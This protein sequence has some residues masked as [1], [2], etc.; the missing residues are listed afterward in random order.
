MI[1]AAA[2]T[3]SGRGEGP[4][5]NPLAECLDDRL[6]DS[7][8]G[9]PFVFGR[10]DVPGHICRRGPRVHDIYYLC[11]LGTNTVLGNSTNGLFG[12]LLDDGPEN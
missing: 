11:S 9:K 12:V 7:E 1:S 10:D 5:L 8:P 3:T 2:L 4:E 6:G